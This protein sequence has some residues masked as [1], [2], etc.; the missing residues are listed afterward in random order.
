MPALLSASCTEYAATAPTDHVLAL[1]AQH[2]ESARAV[3]RRFLYDHSDA[4]DVVHDVFLSLWQRPGCFDPHR[5]TGRAWLLAIIRNRSIDHLRRR[6]GC[7]HEDV[8]ELADRLP[9]VH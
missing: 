4:E 6:A 8:S 5:G 3:A 7:W 9:D 2:A 1:Y